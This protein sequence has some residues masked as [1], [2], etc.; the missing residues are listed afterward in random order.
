MN[1]K[2][3][4]TLLVFGLA[5]VAC[6]PIQTTSGG[7]VGVERKQYALVSEAQVEESASIAYAQETQKAAQK[8]ALNINRAETDRVRRIAARLIPATGTFRTDAPGWKWEV[9][10]ETSDEL[11]AYCMPGGK[12]MVY[13]GLI[14]KL[15]L[16]D[17]ELATVMGHEISHALREHGRER[18]SRQLGQEAVLSLGAALLGV[19]SDAAVGLAN[20]VATVTFQLPHSRE[21]E[22]EADRL[23]LELMARAGYNPNA[24]VSLWQKMQSTGGGGPPQFL[25]TH[26]SGATRIADI[27]ALIPRVMPLYQSARTKG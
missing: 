13:T 24:A 14:E 10:V 7:A 1:W 8:G 19:N 20:Q 26:P 5:L 17:D 9:N 4:T 23:G 6:T 18:V 3:L 12:I 22:S 27:Q 21:Q 2:Y 25:S 11:N 16:S 15:K